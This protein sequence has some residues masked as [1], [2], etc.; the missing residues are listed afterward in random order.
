MAS[1]PKE[2]NNNRHS[3]R[4]EVARAPPSADAPERPSLIVGIGASAGGLEAFRAFLT[5]MPADSGMGFVLVQHLDPHH[6]SML[7]ELL[8]AHTGM[9]VLTADDGTF[10]AANHV[11]VIPPDA[12]LIIEDGRLGVTKPAPA[13]QNRRPIDT[14]FTS[15]AESQGETAVCIVLSG[16][17]S[18]GSLG[19]QKIKEF[20]GLCLAQAAFDETAM[21]GMPQSAAATGLVD[22]VLPVEAMP[23]KLIEYQR[24]LAEVADR[25]D[26]DGSRGDMP[27]HL[28]TITA[29]LRTRIGHDFG[30]YKENTLVRRIQRRM[31]VLQIDD[32]PEYIGRLRKEPGQVEALFGELLIGVTEFF[33]DADAFKALQETA[34]P[35]LIAAGAEAATPVRLWIPGCATGEEVYSLAIM[36]QEVMQQRGVTASAQIFGTDIDA[37]AVAFARSG[38]YRKPL[39]GISAERLGRWFAKEGEDYCPIKSIREMCI[40]ST[41]SVVKDPPFSKLDLLSCRNLLIYLKADLQDRILRTF[42]YAIRPGGYLFLGSSEN[43]TRHTALFEVRDKK[44]RVFQRRE[45]SAGTPGFA[46]DPVVNRPP[47]PS[48]ARIESPESDRLDKIGRR[49]MEKYWPAYVIIDKHHDILR[50]SG[51]EVGPYLKPSQG[52]ASLNLFNVL[53]KGLQHA[54]R[55]AI[56][57]ARGGQQRVVHENLAAKLNGQDRL[58][59]LI[60]EPI[61]ENALEAGHCIVAFQ[62]VD[63]AAASAAVP[64][65]PDAADARLQAL[66]QELRATKARLAALQDDH[67]TTYEEMKSA[68]EE[69][70]SVNEELQASNEELETSR[71]EMQSINEELQ[72]V[73]AE[74]NSKNEMLARLN[75]DIRNFLDS[76][77]IATIFLDNELHIKSFTPMAT[78]LFNLRDSDRG[79]PLTELVSTLKYTNLRRDVQKV[80]S[81][82]STVESEVQLADASDTF[83][84]R[85]R[86]YRTIDNV[87]DGVVMTFVEITDRKAYEV[88]LAERE[89]RF[90]ALVD[91]S[92]QIVWT[93]NAAGEIEE[94]SP[95][96]RQ[97]TGQTYD[98]WKGFGWLDAIHP[99]DRERVNAL[100]QKAVTD[101]STANVEYRL[102]HASG[103][104][105]WNDVRAVPLIADDSVKG[106]VGMNLDISDR[107][108]AE[109]QHEFLLRELNHRVKNTLATVMAIALQTLKGAPSPQEFRK[110]FLARIVALANTQDLL[111]R[112]ASR[113][114]LLKDLVLM[115]LAPYQDDKHPRWTIAGTEIVLRPEATRALGMA[116]HELATNAAKYGALSRTTGR[117][118]V[119]WQVEGANGAQQLHLSWAETGGPPVEAPTRK[120]FGSR[121]IEQGLMHELNATVRQDFDPGGVRCTMIV[122]LPAPDGG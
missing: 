23:A 51:G 52:A 114:V 13:R 101:K 122:P 86:P 99:D 103:A 111:T 61:L 28:A 105:R 96:W 65:L 55:A 71:E 54:A 77:Q 1:E 118:E 41:H 7:V 43:V 25:K 14:F 46:L 106:W 12:T 26:G 8:A 113:E 16:S 107:K 63:S 2:R 11:F 119:T 36:L 62:E 109:A 4:A 19:L 42:H 117:V 73:N 94:D 68:N 104:W 90:R 21:S 18:D 17:G 64:V 72:T 58:V 27:Q 59:T 6:K 78:D 115:E 31:Q 20:G 91:A 70:Q 60:V 98:Q 121:V 93:T 79:R 38:R 102:R 37:H 24:Q 100:W 75:N 10:V 9:P 53:R 34:F 3:A 95:S 56:Q 15:L 85:I 40:F 66:E 44:H 82:L 67:D 49:I 116:L 57:A 30:Q 50:F 89:Q 112:A 92:S 108:E 35:Q 69:Y 74:M 120:G 88:R 5:Q 33:R 48:A 110:A 97:F 87:I 29:L 47:Q 80:L 81:S 22:Y 84:M 39:T 83:V 32:V 45:G 76:T